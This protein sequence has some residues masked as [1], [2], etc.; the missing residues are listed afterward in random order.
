M[1]PGGDDSL[2]KAEVILVV[3]I[4]AL[5]AVG[6]D[7]IGIKAYAAMVFTPHI[8]TK[9]K[10]CRRLNE[11]RLQILGAWHVRELIVKRLT[12]PPRK[13]MYLLGSES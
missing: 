4:L 2:S 12:L 11:Q 6:G 9:D 10:E 1:Q 7:D 3:D 5:D 8:G 13:S